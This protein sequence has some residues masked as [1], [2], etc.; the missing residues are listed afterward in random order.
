MSIE[1]TG[2]H[3]FT[4][5]PSPA[6][7]NAT[8]NRPATLVRDRRSGRATTIVLAGV[9]LVAVGALAFGVSQVLSPSPS[10]EAESELAARDADMTPSSASRDPARPHPGP[11]ARA[12]SDDSTGAAALR[13]E[14]RARDR[15]GATSDRP[16]S[17]SDR[18]LARLEAKRAE[19]RA[20][21]GQGRSTRRLESGNRD[22]GG[23]SPAALAAPRGFATPLEG[24]EAPPESTGEPGLA[25]AP[26]YVEVLG[27]PMQTPGQAAGMQRGDRILEYNGRPI[28][29]RLAL[30]IAWADP[31]LPEVVPVVVQTRGGEVEVR[32]VPRGDLEILLTPRYNR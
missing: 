5:A 10:P 8:G 23:G 1:P 11:A 24:A 29:G 7:R 22:G 6:H 16:S 4:R 19:R 21:S 2:H 14:P 27:V 15:R 9:A 12:P 13:D 20:N 3:A 25:Y 31:T 30:E 28:N 18:L 17:R 32:E 26:G